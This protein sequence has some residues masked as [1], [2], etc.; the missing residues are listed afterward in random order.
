MRNLED[1]NFWKKNYGLLPIHITPQNKDNKF[2]ML[3]GGTSDF[4]FQTFDDDEDIE[5]FFQTSWSTNTKNYLILGND[6]LKIINWY[7]N[8]LEEVSKKN[9]LANSDKFYN[10]LLSK[11]FKSQNDVVPFIIDIFRQLRNLTLER[12]N[13][14][15]A[16]NLLYLLLVSIDEDF[17]RIDFE[18][19]GFNVESIPD[20]FD[21][22]VET[23][24]TGIKSI[25]PDLDLILRHTSGALFQEAHREVIYF[26]PQRDLFGGVSSKLITKA[27]SYSSIHYTPQ[28]IARTIVENCLK[29]IDLKGQEVKIL[30][31][32][33]GSSEFLIEALKQLQELDYKGKITIKGLDISESA[34]NTSRF[35]LEYE[36]RT[37]WNNSLDITLSTVTDSLRENWETDND[38]ILMNPPFISWE[39]MKNKEERSAILDSLG[40]AFKSGKPNQAS[41]FFYKAKKSLAESGILGCVIPSSILKSETYSLLRNE[42]QEDLSIKLLAKLGN[43]V[44]EDALTDVSIFVGKKPKS[45][46]FP[47][48]IW[49]KNEK[50][51]VQ[52]ALREFR[53]LS[54]NNEQSVTDKKFSI[55]TPL[56][57]PL[58]KD[59]WNI[60]TLDESNFIKNIERF[61]Q[62]GKLNYVSKIFSVKQGI[63]SGN[64]NAFIISKDDFDLIPENEKFLYKKVI[65]NDSVKNG[66]IILKNYIWYPYDE[67]NSLFN[68]EEEFMHQAPISYLRLKDYKNILINRPRNS[69]LNWWLLSEHRAWLRKRENRLYSTEFGKSDSFGYDINGDFIVERG[70]AWIP[71]KNMSDD[72]FYF[73]LSVFSSS[74]FDNLLSIFSKPIMS[75]YYLGQTYTK[76]I[77]IPNIYSI[78]KMSNEYVMLVEYGKELSK[79][80]VLAKYSIDDVLLKYFYPKF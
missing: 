7:N 16:L 50:G 69:D 46:F 24:R 68:N 48:I 49:T 63:R 72:D 28:Y 55:Y 17:S 12:E 71:K 9:V 10:Y 36:N 51:I 30:D 22:F 78:E 62:S 54:E 75:G 33:C 25:K 80:N 45:G 56:S 6:N 61:V 15:E 42:I 29:E 35:L 79:G 57:F 66:V 64:N 8:S 2:L 23:V 38:V 77:P 26:N 31:P 70:N 13:P 34:I 74:I 19:W 14:K 67:N 4:C 59:S 21:Y 53:K 40:T 18:K 27:D 41:A 60:I 5:V 20:Q 11:S 65:N 73:Y 32:A 39:L 37:Q 1:K 3:N 43:F 58:I 47:K 76:D 52:E 44:F